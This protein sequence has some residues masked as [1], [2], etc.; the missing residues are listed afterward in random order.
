MRHTTSPKPL[1]QAAIERLALRYVERFATTEGKL[2]DYLRRKLRER[3]WAGEAGADP[4]A[5][6]ARMVA[7]GYVDDRGYAEA[8]AAEMTRRGLGAR[9][10]ADTLRAARV[11][12][13]DR[14]AV[15][16]GGEDDAL[17]A[18]LAFARRRRIGPF[19]PG[20]PIT[21]DVRR[22]QLAAFARAGH[23][24][25]LA[26]RIVYASRGDIIESVSGVSAHCDDG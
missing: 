26:R 1:D 18:A 8:K 19:G 14:A 17:A 12:E 25:A 20:E 6:A 13:A 24:F 23:S 3:G 2:G 15:M 9:R 7:L 11:G 10:V 16:N 5:V 4:A 22:K 21:P